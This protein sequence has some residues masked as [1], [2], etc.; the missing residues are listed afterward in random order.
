MAG[1][2][3]VDMPANLPAS[4]KPDIN[5]PKPQTIPVPKPPYPPAPKK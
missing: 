5:R 2:T 4:K 1:K 3:P